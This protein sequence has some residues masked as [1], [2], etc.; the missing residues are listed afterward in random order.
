TQVG[1][2]RGPGPWGRLEGDPEE[3][4]PKP[5]GGRGERA[6]EEPAAGGRPKCRYAARADAQGHQRDA[7]HPADDPPP[8]DLPGGGQRSRSTAV[9][10]SRSCSPRPSESNITA[11][12][13]NTS[14]RVRRAARHSPI[15]ASPPPA[16]AGRPGWSTRITRSRHS[17]IPGVCPNV[18]AKKAYW[19]PNASRLH[20]RGRSGAV[21][22]P[23]TR[24]DSSVSRANAAIRGPALASEPGPAG[25]SPSRVP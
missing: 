7:R 8:L 22:S 18:P 13:S 21:N 20:S 1:K 25:G 11:G 10:V 5:D 16:G 14:S 3:V 17:A 15:P 12:T 9:P 24:A 19:Q 6:G 2:G 4:P 23:A